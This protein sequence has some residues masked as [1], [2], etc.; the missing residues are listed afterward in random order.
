MEEQEIEKIIVRVA[1]TFDDNVQTF[2]CVGVN[3]DDDFVNLVLL[4][5]T[6]DDLLSIK[7]SE[8]IMIS[9]KRIYKEG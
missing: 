9:S 4:D 6:T 7:K 8:V 3:I 5:N 2:E 1:T